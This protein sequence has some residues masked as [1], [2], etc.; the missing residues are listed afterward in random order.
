MNE[1]IALVDGTI[2]DIKHSE[3][4]SEEGGRTDPLLK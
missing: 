4:L 2:V 1:A 3:G